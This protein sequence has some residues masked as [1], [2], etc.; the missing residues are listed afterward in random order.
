M[1]VRWVA[2]RF[3]RAFRSYWLDLAEPNLGLKTVTTN[4]TRVITQ[5]EVMAKAAKM[6][7]EASVKT[8]FERKLVFL[9]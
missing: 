3:S 2:R 5:A 8:S 9:E 1:D 4:A 7:H 6:G